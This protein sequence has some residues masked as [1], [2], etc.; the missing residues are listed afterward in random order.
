MSKPLRELKDKIKVLS[1]SQKLRASLGQLLVLH[2]E[3]ME[4]KV[5]FKKPSDVPRCYFVGDTW[6]FFTPER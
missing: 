6:L 1:S 5:T 2:V 4:P 3:Q